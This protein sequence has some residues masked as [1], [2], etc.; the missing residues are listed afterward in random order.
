MIKQEATKK[1]GTIILPLLAV[2]LTI[3]ALFWTNRP[4][5]SVQVTW[6]DVEEEARRGGYR[7]IRTDELKEKYE[8][9]SEALL[10][11]D[12]RQAWEYRTGHIKGAINFPMEPTWWSRWREKGALAGILGGDKDRVVVF[13]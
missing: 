7:L 3:G 8:K 4:A 2:L 10:L 13:Y 12:T 6:A 5:P 11:V 1:N 9:G